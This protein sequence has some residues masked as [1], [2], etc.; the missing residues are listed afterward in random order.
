[1]LGARLALAS[2]S[3]LVLHRVRHSGRSTTRV[4][5]VAARGDH[6]VPSGETQRSPPRLMLERSPAFRLP[7]QTDG[8]ARRTV[9][10]AIAIRARIADTGPCSLR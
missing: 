6:A 4:S 2:V 5:P 10:A 8:K 1:V 7:A 3:S 9:A